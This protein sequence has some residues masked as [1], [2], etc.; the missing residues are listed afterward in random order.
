MKR[1]HDLRQSPR[2]VAS[3]DSVV[4]EG[5]EFVG[6]DVS[7]SFE[8]INAKTEYLRIAEQLREL[9]GEPEEVVMAWLEEQ[10]RQAGSAVGF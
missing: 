9:R 10:S 6:P 8:S 5:G 7:G 3:L 1:I 2:V 4:Y